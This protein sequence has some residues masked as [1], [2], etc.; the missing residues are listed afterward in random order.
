MEGFKLEKSFFYILILIAFLNEFVLSQAASNVTHET[1]CSAENLHDVICISNEQ[2]IREVVI[3]T[4]RSSPLASRDEVI[5]NSIPKFVEIPKLL[6][7]DSKAELVQWNKKYNTFI[8]SRI[9]TQEKIAKCKPGY[10]LEEVI[11]ESSDNRLG[12][13]NADKKV[14]SDFQKKYALRNEKVCTSSITVPA[15]IYCEQGILTDGVCVSEYTTSPFYECP[16]FLHLTPSKWCGHLKIESSNLIT[17]NII[18]KTIA[19]CN[20]RKHSGLIQCIPE[21]HYLDIA[22]EN[23]WINVQPSIVKCPAGYYIEFPKILNG[24]TTNSMDSGRAICKFRKFFP[25]TIKCSGRLLRNGLIVVD[26]KIV[27]QEVN[28]IPFQQYVD[29]SNYSC[30][31][32]KREIPSLI[33]PTQELYEKYK[34]N[35]ETW[36]ETFWKPDNNTLLDIINYQRGISGYNNTML[37]D[38]SI[39]NA[40][41]SN[42]STYDRSNT[43]NSFLYKNTSSVVESI[44]NFDNPVN[45]KNSTIKDIE[46]TQEKKYPKI[47]NEATDFAIAEASNKNNIL[48]NIDRIIEKFDF[49]TNRDSK[50]MENLASYLNNSNADNKVV[51]Q[52]PLPNKESKSISYLGEI[53]QNIS[54]ENSTRS[55]KMMDKRSLHYPFRLPVLPEDHRN[56][57]RKLVWSTREK[58]QWTLLDSIFKTSIGPQ[59]FF[60]INIPTHPLS[61]I[62]LAKNME[63]YLT[64][65]TDPTFQAFV[66]HTLS[67]MSMD[68]IDENI[69]LDNIGKYTQPESVVDQFAVYGNCNIQI[70]SQSSSQIAHFIEEEK[71]K[72]LILNKCNSSLFDKVNKTDHEGSVLY[73][74]TQQSSQVPQDNSTLKNLY[75]ISLQSPDFLEKQGLYQFMENDLDISSVSGTPEAMTEKGTVTQFASWPVSAKYYYLDQNL[76]KRNQILY[77]SINRYIYY[78]HFPHLFA[79]YSGPTSYFNRYGHIRKPAIS[80]NR[81]RYGSP[82][83]NFSY[84]TGRYEK[85][86]LTYYIHQIFNYSKPYRHAVGPIDHY[87]CISIIET[88][89][90]AVCP[91]GF[92]LI[93][94]CAIADIIDSIFAGEIVSS[95]E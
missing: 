40:N 32:Q 58:Y 38:H 9:Q 29:I 49:E 34:S 35:K 13:K 31:I 5:Q 24:D 80:D 41:N 93:S 47:L 14:R 33:C 95:T 3:N 85:M 22:S 89:P 2:E 45:P 30:E 6:C 73:A 81:F 83:E 17:G 69:E 75:N 43:L 20:V 52:K 48:S 71:N 65:E 76:I 15:K 16:N 1:S 78:K 64:I 63:Y 11:V 67:L 68:H 77:S 53:Q 19:S 21:Y 8:C 26:P 50:D 42:I 66:N 62:G 60:M 51:I 56:G 57:K 44:V 61:H 72:S 36:L 87:H 94:K 37:S 25:R 46:V 86:D 88:I 84:Y 74:L 39:L 23:S 59:H 55:P 10:I 70:N 27:H 91:K 82:D 4:I 90:Q 79:F 28:P 18:N 12:Y 7:K 54:I 92:A